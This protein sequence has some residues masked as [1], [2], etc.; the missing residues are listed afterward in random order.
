MNWEVVNKMEIINFIIE[1]GLIMIPVLY[2]IGEIIKFT[3]VLNNK[4]I[5][6][7]LLV[8]SLLFTPLLLGGFTPDNIVQAVLVTGVTVLGDQLIKQ[9][10]KVR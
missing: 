5:P 1:E 10:G 9:S 2:I 6:L 3:G 7:T 4:W 8:F